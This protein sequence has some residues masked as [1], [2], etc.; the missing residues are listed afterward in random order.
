MNRRG[1]LGLLGL[2]TAGLVL[3]PERLLW[4]PGR[5]TIF[6]PHPAQVAFF[7]T[8]DVVL[9]QGGRRG[10]G[11][12]L[13][14]VELAHEQ[15]VIAA[16]PEAHE[17]ARLT[18]DPYDLRG[19]CGVVTRRWPLEVTIAG[20]AIVNTES[21]E[22]VW[23]RTPTYTPSYV[24]TSERASGKLDTLVMHPEDRPERWRRIGLG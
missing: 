15:R 5:R 17:W 8:G 3:D 10:G 12:H 19:P 6:L 23:Q 18:A 9:W 2:G 22:A 1:F 4:V 24:A 13:A 11:K 21:Y 20:S 7:R 14:R 16:E